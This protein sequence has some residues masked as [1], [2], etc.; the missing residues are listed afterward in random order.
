MLEKRL[1]TETELVASILTSVCVDG[2]FVL[3]SGQHVDHFHDFARLYDAERFDDLAVVALA[4]S[5]A[6]DRPKLQPQLLVGS[7]RHGAT[8]THMVAACLVN[9][10]HDVEVVRCDRSRMNGHRLVPG[11][12]SLAGQRV[13]VVDDLTT[14]GV[15]LQLLVDLCRAQRADVLGVAVVQ[16][17]NPN[18]TADKLDIPMLLALVTQDL[19]GYNVPAHEHCPLCATGVPI[20]TQYG[21][22]TEY[23]YRFGQPREGTD[24][25]EQQT[26]LIQSG[27]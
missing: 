21:H 12:R 2:H 23:V 20:N 22:G 27:N 19:R 3:P 13:L 15:T 18:L 10:D 24:T 5:L 4:L 17:C 7:E 26:R 1:P 14:S 11:Q 6:I 9:L 8:L 16:S 25:R